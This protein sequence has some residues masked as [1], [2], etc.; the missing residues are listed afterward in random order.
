MEDQFLELDDVSNQFESVI[1]PG[2]REP[3]VGFAVNVDTDALVPV[4][5]V[6]AESYGFRLWARS[7]GAPTLTPVGAAGNGTW[8]TIPWN[9]KAADST[10][11]ASVSTLNGVANAGFNLDKGVYKLNFQYSQV[12]ANTVYGKIMMSLAGSGF[13]QYPKITLHSRPLEWYHPSGIVWGGLDWWQV[14]NI[15]TDPSQL[16]PAFDMGPIYLTVS[17]SATVG[18]RVGATDGSPQIKGNISIERVS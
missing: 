5:L 11:G 14:W 7:L 10:S 15:H 4:T 8:T 9:L 3:S 17:S 2:Y 12:T 18:V 16:A 1:G 6:D 13:D